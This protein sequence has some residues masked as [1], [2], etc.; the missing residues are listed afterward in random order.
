MLSGYRFRPGWVTTVAT[1]LLLPALIGLGF[2]QLDR[3][4]QKTEIGDRYAARGRME[5]VDV[6][7]GTLD[8]ESMDF[9]Q[10]RVRGR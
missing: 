5:P 2:W 4:E 10:A 3:A 8:P 1:A 6:N 9:R 7:R